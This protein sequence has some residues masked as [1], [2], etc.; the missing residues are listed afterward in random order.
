MLPTAWPGRAPAGIFAARPSDP[1]VIALREAAVRRGVPVL[2]APDATTAGVLA[3]V[4]GE[5][6]DG[7]GAVLAGAR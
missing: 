5:I 6:G 2:D 1:T 4:S 7:P 3:A